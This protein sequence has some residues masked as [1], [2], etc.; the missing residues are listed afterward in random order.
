MILRNFFKKHHRVAVEVFI[1][2]L[3][4]YFFI[5]F[6]LSYFKLKKGSVKR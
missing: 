4:F 3:F 6:L 1:L 5:V 2:Q